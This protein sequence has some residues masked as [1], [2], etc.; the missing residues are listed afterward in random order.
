MYNM[1]SLPGEAICE[2][3]EG[4]RFTRGY[5]QCDEPEACRAV[6]ATWKLGLD[7]CPKFPLIDENRNGLKV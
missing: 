2:A 4:C 3:T 7:R 5:C 6:G 1:A